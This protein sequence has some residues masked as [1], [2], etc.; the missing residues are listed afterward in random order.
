MNSSPLPEGLILLLMTGIGLFF[1]ATPFA[2]M[3]EKPKK[4]KDDKIGFF[5]ILLFVAGFLGGEVC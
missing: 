2:T 5:L 1:W 4:E 3:S